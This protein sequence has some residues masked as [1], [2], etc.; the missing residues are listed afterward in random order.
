MAR[1][2]VGVFGRRCLCVEAGSD[3]RMP[4]SMYPRQGKEA[5]EGLGRP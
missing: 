3:L 4:H 1:N 2:N 5:S